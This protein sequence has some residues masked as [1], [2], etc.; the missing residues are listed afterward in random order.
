MYS[1]LPITVIIK[2]AVLLLCIFCLVLTY[3]SWLACFMA[4]TISF[5]WSLSIYLFHLFISLC[6]F[7]SY[8]SLTLSTSLSLFL[9]SFNSSHS[10]F[11]SILNLSIR[12]I[13]L[14]VHLSLSVPLSLN[15]CDQMTRL[16]VQKLA[17]YTSQ[18]W[19]NGIK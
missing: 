14:S 2:N 10:L 18:N 9:T 19:P 12:L 13:S 15:Q 5:L 6:L 16:F 17:L 4:C 1:Q 7:V 8:L 3:F 11:L